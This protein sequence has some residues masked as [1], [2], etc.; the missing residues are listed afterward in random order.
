MP[1]NR[2]MDDENVV[3][4]LFFSHPYP[5]PVYPQNLFYER[6][7]QKWT[8]SGGRWGDDVETQCSEH[9]LESIR[10]ALVK[11]PSTES[12]RITLVNTPSIGDIES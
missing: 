8:G 1:L 6:G 5:L 12:M 2:I 4:H 7:L 9:S 3:P 11:T 10:V